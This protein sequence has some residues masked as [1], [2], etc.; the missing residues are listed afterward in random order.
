[1]IWL[2]STLTLTQNKCNF[3]YQLNAIIEYVPEPWLVSGDLNLVLDRAEKLGGTWDHYS[4]N[5]IKRHWTALGLRNLGFTGSKFTWWNKQDGIAAIFARL[6]KAFANADWIQ[7]YPDAVVRHLPPNT[8][9]HTPIL[10]K[11]QRKKNRKN[12]MFLFIN[13]WTD[14]DSFE[15]IISNCWTVVNGNETEHD[16]L[17]KL[18]RTEQSLEK[19]HNLH[20]KK[21]DFRIAQPKR[22]FRGDIM[23]IHSMTS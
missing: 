4:Q 5:K 16:I 13:F 22:K 20:Y 15:D 10:I 2:V 3:I 23:G 21:L 17:A 14:D 7:S 19:W 9:D 6:D 8:S 12:P 1:M 11:L 18:S